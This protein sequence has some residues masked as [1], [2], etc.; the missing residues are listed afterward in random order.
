MNK[1]KVKEFFDAEEINRQIHVVGV[2]AIGSTL[3]ENLT[4]LGVTEL[5]IYDFDT[6]S[7]H[8]ITNQMF[9]ETQIGMLKV[10]AVEEIIKEINPLVTVHKFS[11]GLTEPYVLNGYIFLCV[12]NI[13][14]RR[15][16]TEVNRYNM[17]TAAIFDFRM[18]LTDAQ[19]YAA[20]FDYEYEQ[21]LRTME[22]SH[23]EAIYATPRSAC[24]VELSV[25]YAP[26]TIVAL[27]VANFVQLIKDKEY[28]NI[29][30]VDTDT[31]ELTKFK[32]K[33]RK[34]KTLGILDSILT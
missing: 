29:I 19:H 16:I 13:D 12:D 22:F 26:R 31:F 14:L 15:T 23:D 34:K 30:M 10:D 27:G 7:A 28:A 5:Y 21:L 11:S 4:R 3:C 8:N 6:V 25:V 20:K 9:K 32:W 1:S 2:G 33:E 18:R 17:N 24:G